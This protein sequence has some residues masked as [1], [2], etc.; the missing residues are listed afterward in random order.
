MIN[1]RISNFGA[2][3]VEFFG[4]ILNQLGKNAIFQLNL[5]YLFEMKN[6]EGSDDVFHDRIVECVILVQFWHHF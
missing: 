3:L 4:T 6:Y 1:W 5:A 2:I